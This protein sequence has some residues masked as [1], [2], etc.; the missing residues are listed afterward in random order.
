MKKNQIKKSWIQKLNIYALPEMVFG[1][2]YVSISNEKTGF[3][4]NFNA[5]DALKAC[6]DYYIK[7]NQLKLHSNVP[8]SDHFFDIV[9]KS[10]NAVLNTK[11]FDLSEVKVVVANLWKDKKK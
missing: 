5:F 1:D 8:R 4:L 2:S 10:E 7:K 11:D 3:T 6:K 9:E